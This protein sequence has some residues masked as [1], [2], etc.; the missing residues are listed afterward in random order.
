MPEAIRSL[1]MTIDIILYYLMF[2]FIQYCTHIALAKG[3]EIWGA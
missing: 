2:E 3:T 1:S